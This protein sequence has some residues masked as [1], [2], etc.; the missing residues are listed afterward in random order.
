MCTHMHRMLSLMLSL[1][2]LLV[3]GARLLVDSLVYRLTLTPTTRQ[4]PG[5]PSS[6]SDVRVSTPTAPQQPSR[7]Q[8]LQLRLPQG[9]R[10]CGRCACLR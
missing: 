9:C 3:Q 7:Q 5:G 10:S 2:C 1:T 8:P 4:Q 6:S